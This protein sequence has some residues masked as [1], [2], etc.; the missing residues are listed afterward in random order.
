MITV[1]LY[2]ARTTCRKRLDSVVCLKLG[3]KMLIFISD[4]HFIDGTAGNHNVPTD[5]FMIFFGHISETAKRLKKKGRKV[6]EIKIVYLGDVFDLLRT[7]KWFD[8][9]EDE[10]PWGDDE[11]KIEE[12]ANIIFDG[13]IGVNPTD[14]TECVRVFRQDHHP[15]KGERIMS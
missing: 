12:N 8:Y 1:A 11:A 3:G 10:R 6:E 15:G 9:P 7:E 4:F 2:L 5:A 13:V 14:C